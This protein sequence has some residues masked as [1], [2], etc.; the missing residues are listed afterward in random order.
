[1]RRSYQHGCRSL[2]LALMMIVVTGCG[3]SGDPQEPHVSSSP[4]SPTASNSP[5]TEAG[6]TNDALSASPPSTDGGDRSGEFQA[7]FEWT[8]KPE[9]VSQS[10]DLRTVAI[11]SLPELGVP[12]ELA[13]GLTATFPTNTRKVQ[14]SGRPLPIGADSPYIYTAGGS[15]SF[16]VSTV[17]C[18]HPASLSDAELPGFM[19]RMRLEHQGKSAPIKPLEAIRVGSRLG[20]L[21][22][23]TGYTNFGRRGPR[24]RVVTIIDHRQIYLD[25]TAGDEITPDEEEQLFAVFAS[26]KATPVAK[27]TQ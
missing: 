15:S 19:T 1:M 25:L 27:A 4:P 11:D 18:T 8:P 14:A 20:V 6:A 2:L 9:P 13:D 24:L 22:R 12:M 17:S 21:V 5:P 10:I 23:D 7:K 3:S 16:E 26:L